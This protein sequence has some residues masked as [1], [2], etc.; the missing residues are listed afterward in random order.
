VSE[1]EKMPPIKGGVDE[2]IFRKLLAGFTREDAVCELIYNSFDADAEEIRITVGRNLFRSEDTG[3]YA[4]MGQKQRQSFF[5]LATPHKEQGS[6]MSPYYGRAYVGIMGLGRFASFNI[7][8][9]LSMETESGGERFSYAGTLGATANLIVNK[10]EIEL[11]VV[12]PTGRNGTVIEYYRSPEAKQQQLQPPL[13]ENEVKKIIQNY[14]ALALDRKIKGPFRIYVNGE[15]IPLKVQVETNNNSIVHE[16]NRVVEGVI[17]E[18]SR[19]KDGHIIGHLE[20]SQPPAHPFAEEGIVIVVRG[21]ALTKKMSLQELVKNADLQPDRVRGTIECD[22]LKF[23]GITKSQVLRDDSYQIQEFD[24]AMQ[25]IYGEFKLKILERAREHQDKGL[26]R[27]KSK[28]DSILSQFV[29][30]RPDLLNLT[31]RVD[32]TKRRPVSE[33]A[34]GSAEL[35]LIAGKAVTATTTPITDTSRSSQEPSSAHATTTP[36][37]E[38]NEDRMKKLRS[39]VNDR[40]SSV[41]KTLNW[42]IQEL[43]GDVPVLMSEEDRVIRVNSK[44]PLFKI[45]QKE[46]RKELM[47]YITDLVVFEA[48]VDR[49]Q[50]NASNANRMRLEF[51][52]FLEDALVAER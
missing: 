45:Y 33:E 39:N 27:V 9:T 24:K 28:V 38:K 44:H 37:D 19:M 43:S 30:T 17:E 26:E 5:I 14:V 50:N 46:G 29:S 40:Y 34:F 32:E 47:R 51:R 31:H 11:G 16:I 36:L 20:Y 2:S 8:D 21:H 15:N 1:K 6:R 48:A 41:G 12:R 49:F 35:H 7:Y 13:T 3:R 10:K 23:G 25:V 52:V 42:M 4:G 22:F 18:G